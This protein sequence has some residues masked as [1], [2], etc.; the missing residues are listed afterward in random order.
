[1]KLLLMTMV[2]DMAGVVPPEWMGSQLL[3]VCGGGDE[4]RGQPWGGA[5][6]SVNSYFY[7]IVSYKLV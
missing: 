3:G 1:M 5:L 7:L 4:P 2:V 6:E